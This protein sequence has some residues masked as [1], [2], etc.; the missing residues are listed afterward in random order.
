VLSLA[1]ATPALGVLWATLVMLAA[2]L[3]AAFGVD[4]AVEH[5]APTP[6]V[7]AGAALILVAAALVGR[8][9]ATR[10]SGRP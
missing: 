8:R 5:E 7:I 10:L 4:W 1:I 2:Q 3:V 9:P 6:G